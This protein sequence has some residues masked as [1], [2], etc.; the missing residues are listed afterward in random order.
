MGKYK[1]KECVHR[2]C[3]EVFYV[4]SREFHMVDICDKCRF[5]KVNS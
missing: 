4:S 3:K 2:N 5:K 1:V